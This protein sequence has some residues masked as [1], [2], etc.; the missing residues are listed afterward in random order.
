MKKYEKNTKSRQPHHPD[1][2]YVLES[3]CPNGRESPWPA[4]RSLGCRGGTSLLPSVARGGGKAVQHP[5]GL[6]ID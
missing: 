6:R 4:G 3:G 5:P 2:C 1:S